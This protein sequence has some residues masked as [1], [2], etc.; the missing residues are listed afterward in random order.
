ML[1]SDR[2]KIRMCETLTSQ[3]SLRWRAIN[4][5]S[6][7]LLDGTSLGFTSHTLQSKNAS[8]QL[9]KA[10]VHPSHVVLNFVSLPVLTKGGPFEC[11]DGTTSR[12]ACMNSTADRHGTSKKRQATAKAQPSFG[13]L[14]RVQPSI[15]ASPRA[16]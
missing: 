12:A 15:G 7:W 16:W 2:I 4:C 3:M 10:I 6:P 1:A 11:S 13:T 8:M 5:H 14:P 9:D